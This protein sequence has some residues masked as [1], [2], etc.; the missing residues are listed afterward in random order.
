MELRDSITEFVKKRI[1][2]WLIT[3][4]ESDSLLWFTDFLRESNPGE[5]LNV[6]CV[7]ANA[8][9]HLPNY[10]RK[11]QLERMFFLFPVRHV[12]QRPL[13]FV[14]KQD[15]HFKVANHRRRII[16]TN[17][18]TVYA[19]FL[20]PGGLLYTTTDVEELAVWMVIHL[21]SSA[22]NSWLSSCRKRSW[23]VILC[24][25]LSQKWS[26]IKTKLQISYQKPLKKVAK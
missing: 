22:E 9:K 16:N 21:H 13:S 8:M 20:Q 12:F 26:S 14:S 4:L 10:F 18:L 7:R 25:N 3:C 17:L 15:P 1:G 23:T 5:Y 11:G 6:A 19:H 2:R 24:L